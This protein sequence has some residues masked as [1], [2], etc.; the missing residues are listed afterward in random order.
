MIAVF[1]VVFG[2]NFLFPTGIGKENIFQIYHIFSRQAEQLD[3]IYTDVKHPDELYEGVT[4]LSDEDYLI[5]RRFEYETRDADT[6]M[7]QYCSYLEKQGF[8][9]WEETENSVTLY[10]TFTLEG[11]KTLGEEYYCIT[12][13]QEEAYITIEEVLGEIE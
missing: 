10:K 2:L 6:I 5:E 13:T 9:F 3:E 8:V 7:K 11:A 4:L 12:V 1:T